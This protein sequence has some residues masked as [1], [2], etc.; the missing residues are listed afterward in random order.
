[1]IR[2]I[3]SRTVPNQE[4]RK[5]DWSFGQRFQTS[6]QAYAEIAIKD[7]SVEHYLDET[8]HCLPALQVTLI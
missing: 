8:A 3:E 5:V 1:M 6:S 7:L 4:H 2:N